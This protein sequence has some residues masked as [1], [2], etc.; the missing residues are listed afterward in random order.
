MSDETKIG[1]HSQAEAVEAVNPL[2]GRPPGAVGNDID[3]HAPP[4]LQ[5]EAIDQMIGD[6]ETSP[7]VRT[8]REA[9]GNAPGTFGS[10][11][12]SDG[13]DAPTLA[14]EVAESDRERLSG[15]A[16]PSR[17]GIEPVAAPLIM[18]PD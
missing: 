17:E 9:G 11:G 1:D 4:A 2:V 15:E 3:P 14:E 8:I 16:D 12:H 10:S 18:P 6:L 7:E 5:Q 13:E